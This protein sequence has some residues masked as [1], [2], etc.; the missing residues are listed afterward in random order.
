MLAI[1]DERSGCIFS[2]VVSKGVNPY[3]LHLVAEALKFLGRKKV[4]LFTDAEHS[5]K[6][7]AEAVAKE[8]KGD[9][10]LM[11]APRES[12]ASN[13]I[14]ERGVLELAKQTRTLVSSIESKFKDK[15]PDFK[16][17]PGEKYFP[18]IVRHAA[19]LLTRYLIKKDGKTPYEWKAVQW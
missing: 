2:G 12:H 14:A 10:Q 15:V 13:A 19:W 6:A 8:Y 1:V 7:L 17:L 5:I 3:S 4:I 18:W 9:V 11:T 16:V